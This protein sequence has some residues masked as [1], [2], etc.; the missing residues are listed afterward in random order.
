M[1]TLLDYG[2]IGYSVSDINIRTN[3][4]TGVPITDYGCKGEVYI[5]VQ[6]NPLHV[7]QEALILYDRHNRTADEKTFTS[8][9]N[10][11]NWLVEN[12]VSNGNYSVLPYNFTWPP[13][14]TNPPWYSALAQSK[15]IDVLAK[16][17]QVTGNQ[18]YLD[19]AKSLL[20]AF[21]VEV[22]DGGVTLKTPDKGWWYEE[23][24]KP[25]AVKSGV[26]SGMTNSL[27][28]IYN[29]SQYTKDP[30]AKSLFDQGVLALKNNLPRFEYIGGQYSTFDALNNTQPASVDHHIAHTTQLGKLYNI[31]GEQVF[32][33]YYD[34]WTNFT[35]PSGVADKM[36]SE[37]GSENATLSCPSTI[38][39]P[40]SQQTL[41]IKSC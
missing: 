34:R 13:Y 6:R 37:S 40:F 22:D 26:L 33:N 5:G 10:N 20:N 23:Y 3:D 38:R 35:L 1:L 9:I 12:A 24:A 36:R 21:F 15:A 19:V 30:D 14:V 31:T 7:A 28:S 29:Y 16:A 8:F 18:T 32:R 27:L 25:G 39:D 2:R 4:R 41:A 17:H 11:S